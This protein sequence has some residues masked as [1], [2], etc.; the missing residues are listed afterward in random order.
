ML[1]KNIK[2]NLIK[3]IVQLEEDNYYDFKFKSIPEEG[4]LLDENINIYY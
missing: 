3:K 1:K 2:K 4:V